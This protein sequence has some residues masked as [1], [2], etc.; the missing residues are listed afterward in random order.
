M[1]L[2]VSALIIASVYGAFTIAVWRACR[3]RKAT[4]ARLGHPEAVALDADPQVH[5]EPLDA[6][7][8][9]WWDEGYPED[10]WERVPE[11]IA[12][13]CAEAA[14]LPYNLI[15]PTAAWA[16]QRCRE[17]YDEI[18]GYEA[19]GMEGSEQW[20]RANRELTSLRPYRFQN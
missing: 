6:D 9:A 18:A 7:V 14:T 13:E 12:N 19:A 1:K 5:W 10:P 4:K 16:D 2:I 20:L 3:P 8:R 17:L 11:V 15:R